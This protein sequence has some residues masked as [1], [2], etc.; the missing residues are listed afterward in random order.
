MIF[1]LEVHTL[2]F[3]SHTKHFKAFPQAWTGV[4]F[5]YT[6]FSERY[7]DAEI[8]LPQDQFSIQEIFLKRPVVPILANGVRQCEN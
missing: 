8:C 6:A 5:P 4:Y 3:D 2:N 7:P 1:N